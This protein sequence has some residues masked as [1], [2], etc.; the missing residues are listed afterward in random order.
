M[1]VFNKILG[2]TPVNDH[3][4]ATVFAVFRD[5]TICDNMHK[6][7]TSTKISRAILLPRPARGFRD[8][9]EQI[10][11]DHQVAAQEQ[12]LSTAKAVMVEDIVE[13]CLVL[14]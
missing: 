14:V 11:F 5:S 7:Y 2:S 13:T 3:F 1:Y 9:Y 8:R 6:Q 4:S 12:Q 10:E